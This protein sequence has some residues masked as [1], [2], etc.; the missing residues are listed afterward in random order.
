MIAWISENKDWLLSGIIP[1]ILVLL[2]SKMWKDK[3]FSSQKIKSGSH[4]TN[5]QVSGN[6]TITDS[7]SK[8]VE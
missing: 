2:L 5:T 8:K 7:P 1:T 4:S 3:S 6:V